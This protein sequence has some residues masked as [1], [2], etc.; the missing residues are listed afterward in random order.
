MTPVEEGQERLA[1]WAIVGT[2]VT[3][4]YHHQ[5]KLFWKKIHADW[6]A[7][8]RMLAEDPGTLVPP[9]PKFRCR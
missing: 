8:E 3:M 2:G 5:I 4:I 6:L 9:E 7:H 1:P